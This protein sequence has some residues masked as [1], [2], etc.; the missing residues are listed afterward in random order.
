MCLYI[1]DCISS[2]E[3]C[4]NCERDGQKCVEAPLR[5]CSRCVL[6]GIQCVRLL[7]SMWSADCEES[8]KQ[9]MLKL[10]QMKKESTLSPQL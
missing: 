6:A 3:V 4:E 5:A 2:E 8:N 1:L 9:A 7:V 10:A